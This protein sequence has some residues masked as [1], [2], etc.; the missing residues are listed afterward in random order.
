MII[1]GVPAGTTNAEMPSSVRAVTVTIEVMSV[2]QLVMKAFEPLSTHWSPSST[3]RCP[4]CAG[5]G[6]TVGFGEAERAERSPR[7]E[8]G[9]PPVALLVGA[10]AE[11]RVRS[12]P[13]TRRQGDPHRLVDTAELLDGD[14]QRRE[15]ATTTAPLFGEHDAEQAEVAHRLHDVDRE[16]TRPVPLGGMRGDVLLGEL[17]HRR[18][19]QFVIV[20]QLPVHRRRR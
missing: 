2:P 20:A 14:A 15:V 18:P 12:E 17:A 19:Q 13:D 16:M 3:A 10:E 11:D 9:Q 1:P 8:V 5:V 4:G 6:P 7:D